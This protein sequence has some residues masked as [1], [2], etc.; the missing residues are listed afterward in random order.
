[1]A[2]TLSAG[3]AFAQDSTQAAE[4]ATQTE[5]APTTRGATNL[6]KVTV[7]GSRIKRAEIEGPAPVTIVTAADIEKQGFN[8]VYDA[9][10]TLS[11][12]T[13]SVQNE[14]TAGGFTQN[15]SFLNLR[16]LGPGYQLILVNGRRAADYPLP[17]NG[18]SNAVNL[19]NIPAAAIERIEV[20]SGGASAIYGSDA[21]A[22]VVNVILKTNYEG[23]LV[24]LRGGTTTRGG[25]D[26]G[27]VQWI[28]GKTG[29]NWSVT[30]A[31]ELLEREAIY[32]RQRDFMD[33]YRDD[34]SVDPADALPVEGV[35]FTVNRGAGAIR[36]WPDGLA[37]TCGRFSQ[38]ET[39]RT[40]SAQPV[41]NAC[42]YFGYPATQ[43]IRNSDSSIAGY[44]YGTYDFDG[45]M[46]AWTQ[47]GFNNSK[48]KLASAT[49]F[50]QSGAT[51]GIGNFY[52][53]N[54]GG[55]VGN[56]LRIF[57]PEEVGNVGA[58]NRYDE[59]SFDVA[60][61][62]RGTFINDRFDWDAT[63]SHA[64]YR[65]DDEFNWPVAS[66]VRDFFFGQRL[67]TTGTGLPIYNLRTDRLLRPLTPAEVQSFSET[68]SSKADSEVTQAS[69]SVSGDLFELPAGAVGMAAILEAAQQE[70]DITPDARMRLDYT[71]NDAPMG[72]TATGGGGDRTRYALGVEFSIPIFE[73]FR[74]NIAGRHD[75]YDDA[76]SVDGASTWMAGLEWR[77]VDSLLLR[78][79]HSTSFRA[80][81]MHYIFA[82]PSG[83]FLNSALDEY[84]CRRDG[85]NP[86]SNEDCGSGTDYS[87]SYSGQREGNINLKEETGK[88]TTIGFVWD[89]ADRMSVSVDY[90]RIKLEGAVKDIA[91]SYL[92]RNEADC[93]LGQTRDGSPVDVNSSACQYFRSLIEREGINPALGEDEY[94]LTYNSV[95][96]NQAMQETT[97]ID[98]SFKYAL[99][100]D[101]MGDFNFGLNWTH[102]L[103]LEDQEFP[104]SGIRNIRDHKQFFNF[105]SR[106]NWTASWERNDWAATVY[107]YRWGSLPNWEETGRIGSYVI[108][109]ANVQKKLTEKA[110]LGLYVNNVF[111]DLAPE[112]NSFNT[113]PFF[114]GAYSPIGREV[115]VQFDYKFR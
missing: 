101:R 95:P 30:Y 11:Q 100:T 56:I 39:Y 47:L 89:I 16:G 43:S 34:P 54:F 68:Y 1:M 105:R 66:R 84:R 59:L 31:A 94:V 65:A 112:D 108:W 55:T 85:L 99:D 17:Y 26:S 21:V 80:P 72:R 96:F 104:G 18:Q 44:L 3:S 53:P 93:R 78:A 75:K 27:R 45:G 87:Y 40:T 42:G 102:V 8:T 19:A 98:A 4:Q 9:L 41:P 29:D 60:A 81:D 13:G 35:R 115:F 62:L 70:Y 103:K 37:A 6:D 50:I 2:M 51:L 14:L 109:N 76:S 52:D 38:F 20:L 79:S 74:A 106:I 49:R 91:F 64:R 71:G 107:G 86:L 36:E 5:N 61:G 83:F 25:G 32:A 33:S 57:T 97:G 73:T 113:Y 69:F 46:Q 67:G 82:Q 111:D 77:P 110:T 15:A 24:T 114:W 12:F 92:S 10:N 63:V 28:G 48:A 23:D 88:S 22:G 90:Y 58:E 7:T